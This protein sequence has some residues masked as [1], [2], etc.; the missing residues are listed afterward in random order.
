MSDQ[1]IYAPLPGANATVCD[2]CGGPTNRRYLYYTRP[3]PGRLYAAFCES[4]PPDITKLATIRSQR[5]ALAH[6]AQEA[7]DAS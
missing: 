1:G 7:T 2:S 6:D 4:C 3:L 5:E